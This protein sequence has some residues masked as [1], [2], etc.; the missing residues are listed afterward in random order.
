MSYKYRTEKQE[1]R[2][3]KTIEELRE[4]LFEQYKHNRNVKDDN[5]NNIRILKLLT[6][7]DEYEEI[8]SEKER[9]QTHDFDNE[10]NN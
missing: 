4:K 2:R 8:M 5:K 1:I 10:F 7:I 6:L 3:Y 9:L